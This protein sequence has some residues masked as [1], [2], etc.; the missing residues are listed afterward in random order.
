MRP[1]YVAQ[2]HFDPAVL[3]QLG[4]PIERLCADSRRVQ[5][6]DTFVAYP[7]EAQDGR[8]HIGAALAAGATSV[9]W[10]S[11]GFAWDAAWSVPNLGIAGLRGAVGEI[12]SHVYGHPSRE[13]WVIGVTGT[14]GKTSCAH[15]LAQCLSALGRKTAV[16]GTLGNGFLGE[17]APAANTTPDA[18]GLHALLREY[19]RQGAQCVAMEVS[20]HGLAQGRVAGVAFDVALLTNL[21]RDHL[22]YHGD[23]ESYARTK[24]GL[25]AWRGLKQ[26]VLNLDDEFGASLAETLDRDRVNVVGYGLGRGDVR[27]SE[28]QVNERGLAMMVQTPWGDGQIGSGLVGSFNASNLL[29]VLAA[30]LVSDVALD[31]ALQQLSLVQAPP[32]R[33]QRIGGDGAPLVVVDYAHTPDALEKVLRTLREIMALPKPDGGGRHPALICVFGCGGERDKG[34]RPLMGE[35]VSRLADSVIVTSDNPRGED[36]HAI[37]ADICAGLRANHH[38]IEDRASAI[39]HAIAQAHAGDVVLIAGKG[40]EQYQEIHGERLPFSD[41]D[42]A[43]RA[44]SESHRRRA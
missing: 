16:L 30:L 22:D 38:V 19:L 26:A 8:T 27:G 33:M 3:Q 10:E 39:F 1:G 18:I 5:P 43:Q 4:A 25:F 35:V 13:L 6:G 31:A 14:N 17:L 36:A 42:V 37:I 20:S 2:A 21:S 12:A 40:H 9:L 24:A 7:G 32:G 34:K 41:L 23:M 15:W 28:L 11:Q 29:G 44:L